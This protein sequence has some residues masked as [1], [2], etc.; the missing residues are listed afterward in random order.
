MKCWLG[1]GNYFQRRGGGS[2]FEHAR[3]KGGARRG[4]YDSYHLVQHF[5]RLLN[6]S[7]P[8]L[9]KRRIWAHIINTLEGGVSTE[10]IDFIIYALAN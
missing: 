3:G 1:G 4:A 5:V 6:L 2:L 8:I 10:I 7:K 9:R